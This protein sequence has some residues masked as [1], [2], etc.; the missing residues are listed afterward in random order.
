MATRNTSSRNS[1]LVDLVRGIITGETSEHIVGQNLTVT[2]T[3][4]DVQSNGGLYSWATV[5]FRIELISTD[6]NDTVAG[7]GARVITVSGLKPD[8]TKI[9]VDIDMNGTSASVSP[10]QEFIRVNLAVV[11]ETGTY[12]TDTITGTSAGDITIRRQGGGTTELEILNGFKFGRSM[13]TRF[14]VPKDKIAVMLEFK[15]ITEGN[16]LIDIFC[17]KREKAGVIVAP[18]SPKEVLFDFEEVIDE[19]PPLRVPLSF[20]EKTDIWCSAK[21]KTGNSMVNIL[22]NLLIIDAET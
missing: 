11:K 12:V 4:Q 17:W 9:E 2:T 14:T 16:K 7:S 5:P 10:A 21:T 20:P 19:E 18:F 15:A 1:Y 13:S 8:F 3:L 6:V 22:Y